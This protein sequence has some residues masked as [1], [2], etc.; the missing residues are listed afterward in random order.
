[1]GSWTELDA[2]YPP[3]ALTPATA[4]VV[5]LGHLTGAS[6]AYAAGDTGR[7]A[8]FFPHPGRGLVADRDLL[9]RVERYLGEIALDD[10]LVEARALLDADQTRCLLLNLFDAVLAAGRLPSDDQIY[11]RIAAGLGAPAEQIAPYTRAL[12]LKNDLSLFPQ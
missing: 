2:N 12:I 5:A 4:F 9:V 10:F 7:L 6:S 8:D 3:G 1:M 11:T